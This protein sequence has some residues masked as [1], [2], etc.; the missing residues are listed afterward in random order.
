MPPNRTQLSMSA[1]YVPPLGMIGKV[2]DRA[3]L[4]RVAEATLKDF[5]DRVGDA[6]ILAEIDMV[7]GAIPAVAD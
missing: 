3:I 6:L 4:S 2:I 1:R 5:L 7:E